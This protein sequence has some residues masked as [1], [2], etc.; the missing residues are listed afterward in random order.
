MIEENRS[1]SKDLNND[2]RMSA[3]RV[4]ARKKM[5]SKLSK[6]ETNL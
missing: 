6:Y 1:Q 5:N 3:S 2:S 4:R